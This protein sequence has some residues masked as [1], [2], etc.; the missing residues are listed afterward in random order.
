M[1][2][3]HTSS[4]T[5]NDMEFFSF[6]FFSICR[7]LLTVWRI[8]LARLGTPALPWSMSR[9]LAWV[10]LES[11]SVFHLSVGGLGSG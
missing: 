3:R 6:F 4:N 7:F 9:L 5:P 2:I 11:D 1:P 8:L 10:C